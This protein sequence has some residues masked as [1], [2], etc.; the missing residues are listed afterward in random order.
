MEA[1]SSGSDHHVEFTTTHWSI[2]LGAK[3]P[4]SPHAAEALEKLCRSYWKPLYSYARRKGYS[5]DDSKDYV[6][7]FFSDFL[8]RK[9]LTAVDASYGKFRTFLLRCLNNFIATERKRN[10]AIK[11]G[12]NFDFVSMDDTEFHGD[13]NPSLADDSDPEQSFDLD[14]AQAVFE[15]AGRRLRKEYVESGKT[16]EYDLLNALLS[17]DSV[18]PYAKLAVEL[19]CA[20]ATVKVT[21]HRLRKRF[22]E[23]LVEEVANTLASEADVK[24]E[25]RYLIGL[26]AAKGVVK[27]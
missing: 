3:D 10:G 1:A 7:G 5:P 4:S 17:G 19:G 12:R 6:Q 25:L 27:S 16:N 13:R 8:E 21:A 24:E 15:N 26:L 22:R 14:W 23:L 18:A 2:V 20:E 11:R 9:S